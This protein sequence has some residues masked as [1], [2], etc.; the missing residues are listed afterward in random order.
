MDSF[1]E[2]AHSAINAFELERTLEQYFIK[3]LKCFFSALGFFLLVLFQPCVLSCLYS[4]S[5]SKAQ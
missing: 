4:E 3:S 5:D 2:S 1:R